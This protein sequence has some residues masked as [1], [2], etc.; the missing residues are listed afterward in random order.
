MCMHLL[1]WVWVWVWVCMHGYQ[2]QC[3]SAG[4]V[5]QEYWFSWL[6]NINLPRFEL[7]ISPTPP[8]S[9]FSVLSL[10]HCRGKDT[11]LATGDT[12]NHRF[13]SFLSPFVLHTVHILTVTVSHKHIPLVVYL[14]SRCWCQGQICAPQ[15]L[16]NTAK[17]NLFKQRNEIKCKLIQPRASSLKLVHVVFSSVNWW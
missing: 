17:S 7:H 12:D 10:L 11:Q 13:Y 6:W 9:D 8:P 15:N 1:L 5:L 4:Q 14:L 16:C 2:K 3:C